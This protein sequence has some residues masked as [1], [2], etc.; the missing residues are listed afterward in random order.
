MYSQNT[1]YAIISMYIIH[2]TAT[3][4]VYEIFMPPILFSTFNENFSQTKLFRKLHCSTTQFNTAT[5]KYA[6]KC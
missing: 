1:Q 6:S 5:G 3:S 2:T 4:A